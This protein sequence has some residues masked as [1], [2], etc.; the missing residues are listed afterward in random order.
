[1]LR[2]LLGC[3]GLH[4][5]SISWW[6]V[7]KNRSG[8]RVRKYRRRG[9]GCSRRRFAWMLPVRRNVLLKHRVQIL[10][11]LMCQLGERPKWRMRR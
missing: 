11:L 8:E 4:F 1:M 3:G 6:E 2:S 7:E 10:V 9:R 5:V